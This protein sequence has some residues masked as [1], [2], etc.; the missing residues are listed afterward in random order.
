MLTHL[1]TPTWLIGLTAAALICGLGIGW[2]LARMRL[3]PRLR[4]AGAE[5][6]ALTGENS[7]LRRQIELTEQ[8]KQES[9]ELLQLS[10]DEQRRTVLAQFEALSAKVLEANTR[11]LRSGNK[12]FMDSLLAPLKIQLEGLSR[13]VRDTDSTNAAHKATLE[14]LLNRVLVQTRRLDA[15]AA[16]LTKALTGESK[17]QGDWGEMILERILEDSGLR[18]DEEYFLQYAVHN[19]E[20]RSLRPDVLLRLPGGHHIII[21]SKVSL[22]HYA[23]YRAADSAEEQERL[24][25][26]HVDSVR[27]HIHELAAKNYNLH[28]EGAVG[29]VLMFIPNESSY[30]AAMQHSPRLPSEAY[31]AGVILISPGNL[32]M[33]LQLAYHLWQRERLDNNI[34][35]ILKK[36]AAIYD[37]CVGLSDSFEEVGKNLRR[38]LS[39][40]DEAMAR[41]S[42]GKG[43]LTRQ[44]EDLRRM[45]VSPAK[46]LNLQSPEV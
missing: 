26:A 35:A 20:G 24:L 2:A 9:L 18:K 15:E 6:S 40:Y 31:Q 13:A 12:E 45:G 43:N 4:Q 17:T 46:R 34:S 44:V 3:A 8:H 22:T 27:R 10:L 32:L 11:Q 21:D 23:A 42:S 30:I 37:K 29:H 41:F 16:N 14:E 36:A 5:L 28:T 38:T 33:A 7:L 1:L 25:K 39:S 19:A